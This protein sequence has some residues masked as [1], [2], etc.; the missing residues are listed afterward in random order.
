MTEKN[1]TYSILKLSG[2]EIFLSDKI[3]NFIRK[4]HKR[5][6][7]IQL[8]T[9]GINLKEE[10]I[11][12]VGKFGNVYFQISLDGIS[13]EAN[14]AR[15]SNELLLKKVLKNINLI[16][17]LNMGL[18]I[19]CVLTK[20]NIDDLKKFVEYFSKIPHVVIFPR[21]VRGNPKNRLYPDRKQIENFD[22][23]LKNY[24]KYSAVLPPY[25]YLE[26]VKLMLREELRRWNCYVPYFVLSENN[27]GKVSKCTC[28]SFVE[29]V[30]D[31]SSANT[32]EIKMALRKNSYN[33]KIR[34]AACIDCISQY[35]IFN[36][37]VDNEISK[38]EI[39]NIPTFQFENVLNS[40]YKIK[41]KITQK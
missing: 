20:F 38:D 10:Q 32:D 28:G 22:F 8:L 41:E 4:R 9:N 16:S 5:Y 11:K 24:K 7:A 15:F 17:D 36:L 33:H 12:E 23:L 1:F 18:E 39:K 19:N 31:I 25:K 35:E 30:V 26:R 27:Y 29:N 14:R 34:Y 3:V 2:G 40:I 37:L 21:P 13:S 6:D